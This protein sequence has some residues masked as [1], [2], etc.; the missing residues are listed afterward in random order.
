MRFFRLVSFFLLIV[1]ASDLAR[2]RRAA[3]P[4][5]PRDPH[6]FVRRASERIEQGLEKHV[7]CT[8]HCA[9]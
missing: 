2:L 8:V 9:K 4:T 3:A 7:Y 1:P 5:S 6:A